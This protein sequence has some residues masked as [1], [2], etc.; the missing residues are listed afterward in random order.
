M[1]EILKIDLYV[2]D[3]CICVRT[4]EYMYQN[5]VHVNTMYLHTWKY[6]YTVIYL[7]EGTSKSMLLKD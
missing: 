7:S 3:S 4:L 1:M 5:L 2:T 6:L